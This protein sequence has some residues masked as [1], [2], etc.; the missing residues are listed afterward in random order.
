MR[1]VFKDNLKKILGDKSPEE[2]C[3]TGSNRL[4]YVSG[5][6]IAKPV[7]P[8]TLRYAVSGDYSPSIELIEAIAAKEDLQPYQLLLPELDPS[9]ASVVIT[10]TQDDMLKRIAKDLETLK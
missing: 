5:T 6:K 7:A 1:E 4:R 8:R 10:K 3:G 9:N 2:Y